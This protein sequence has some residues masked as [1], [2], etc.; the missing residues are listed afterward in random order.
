[1]ITTKVL[2]HL[3]EECVIEGSAEIRD[4]DEGRV[5]P[6]TSCATGD[7]GNLSFDALSEEKAFW[8]YGINRIDYSAKW[9]FKNAFEGL[10]G[11]KVAFCVQ[12]AFRISK[13]S[14][15]VPGLQM[16]RPE[17][18]GPRRS[19]AQSPQIGQH[20]TKWLQNGRQVLRTHPYKFCKCCSLIMEGK[21]SVL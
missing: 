17:Y 7:D 2:T 12:V 16:F 5:T 21:H 10:V 1:M 20:G 15:T 4:T 3:M 13:V 19:P 14:E 9:A 18:V 6:S 8:T 11:K